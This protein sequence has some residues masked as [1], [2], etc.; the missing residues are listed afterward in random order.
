MLDE[1]KDVSK[2]RFSIK[3]CPC[4]LWL[5]LS[6]CDRGVLILFE[7]SNNLLEGERTETFNSQDGDV[8]LSSFGSGGLKIVVYLTGT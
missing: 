3:P 2:S 8:I 7:L 6:P 1:I 4:I 5:L